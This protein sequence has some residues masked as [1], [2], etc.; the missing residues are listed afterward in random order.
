MRRKNCI[1]SAAVLALGLPVA[2]HAAVLAQYGFGPGHFAADGVNLGYKLTADIADPNVTVSAITSPSTGHGNTAVAFDQTWDGNGLSPLPP[3]EGNMLSMGS[4]DSHGYATSGT[5]PQPA[6]FTFTLTAAAG[7]KLSLQSLVTDAG[8]NGTAN[9]Q[10]YFYVNTSVDGAWDEAHAI[11]TTLLTAGRNAAGNDTLQHEVIDLSGS[12]YQG[13][14]N[15]TFRIYYDDKSWADGS[16][17][18]NLTINGTA[19]VPEPAGLALLGLG[20]LLT[21]ARRR[22]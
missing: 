6:Y 19:A 14:D 18:D 21:L 17:F 4:W 2:S 20:G 1:I 7:A 5:P 3:G 13:L 22:R 12:Q 8:V 16:V 15:I 10:Q 11:K 9:G